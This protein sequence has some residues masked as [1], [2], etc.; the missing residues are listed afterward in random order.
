MALWSG[1]YVLQLP[2]TIWGHEGVIHPVLLYDEEDGATLVDAGMPGHAD[3][4]LRELAGLGLSARALRRVILTHQDLDHIGAAQAIAAASGAQVLAHPD[5]APFIRGEETLLKF[6]PE[7]AE[8]RLASLKPSDR[9]AMSEL[10]AHLPSAPVH[11]LLADG[12]VLP[13]HGGITVLHTP[14]HTPGHIC[15]YLHRYRLLLAGDALRVEE[16]TLLGPNPQNT[17]DLAAATASLA[18][19]VPLG[20]EYVLCYHGGRYGP[21]AGERLKALA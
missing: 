14:G 20:A 8:A 15:L 6:R 18:K 7:R 19:L 11:G 2:F 16:G 17:L 21:N 1:V 9:A 5:D 13:V 3:D 10:L 12:E 4:I